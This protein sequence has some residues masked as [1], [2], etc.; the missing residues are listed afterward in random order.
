M[1][2]LLLRLSLLIY[3]EVS[4][5][6]KISNNIKIEI[7]DD[8][9]GETFKSVKR[10]TE[11]LPDGAN[12]ELV[13]SCYGGLILNA[14]AIIDT[15]KRFHTKAN[16]VGFACSA[17]AILALSCD[18]CS[19]SENSSLLLHSV[20]N[21]ETDPDD[22][23]IKHCNELQLKLIRKRCPD[24]DPKAIQCDTWLSA[25]ECLKLHL[26]DNIYINDNVDYAALCNRYAALCKRYAAKLSNTFK[27]KEIPRMENE[28][29]NEV[30]EEVKEEV[31]EEA[32][33]EVEN[34][35]LIEVIEKLSEEINALKARVQALEEPMVEEREEV[36]EEIVED[37]R[38]R[39]NNL[40]KN[41]VAPQAK[42]AIAPKA[43]MAKKVQKIDYKAFKNFING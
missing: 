20:W 1:R 24:F 12:V 43:A 14:I 11:D 5:E 8:I 2:L 38:E 25:D 4:M 30:V 33:P 27:N 22:P 21:D 34:H 17:A 28:K 18:E 19:M 13:I 7:V 23:G 29:I 36:K 16:I 42:V 37:D 3:S 26:V 41:I 9:T 10:Q 40:Y 32:A 31:V 35:D 6:D 15:L 39:I